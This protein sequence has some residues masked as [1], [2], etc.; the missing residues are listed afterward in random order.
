MCALYPLRLRFILPSIDRRIGSLGKKPTAAMRT[1]R[2]ARTRPATASGRKGFLRE[3][4][5]ADEL[6]PPR[7]LFLL[8]PASASG[9]RAEILLRDQAQ[10]DLARRLRS[11]EGVPLGDVFSF[12]SGLYFRGKLAYATRF[13]EDAVWVITP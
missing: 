13:G 5:A 1:R 12:L 6:M 9:R 3:R 10:F 7:R 4:G 2:L 11:A 8:S